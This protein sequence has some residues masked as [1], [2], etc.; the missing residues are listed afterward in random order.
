MF[1]SSVDFAEKVGVTPQTVRE[2]DRRGIV[3]PM[4]R[5]ITGIRH[6]TQEQVDVYLAGQYDS[7]IL[8]GQ[9]LNGVSVSESK[10]GDI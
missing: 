2:W 6:Y 3:V 10:E 1:L 4:H 9:A 8:K 7:P 5:S